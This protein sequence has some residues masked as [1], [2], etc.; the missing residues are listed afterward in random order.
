[1][2]THVESCEHGVKSR[3][4]RCESVWMRC[5]KLATDACSLGRRASSHTPTMFGSPR[6][7]T[8]P[9]RTVRIRADSPCA[10]VVGI[11]RRASR[12][13]QS[14]R[15]CW[16]PPS[17]QLLSGRT[18]LGPSVPT[19]TIGT[20]PAGTLRPDS[21]Y[22]DAPCWEPPSRQL[23]SG[24]TLPGAYAHA[25]AV[26]TGAVGVSAASFAAGIGDHRRAFASLV[27]QSA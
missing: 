21:Y 5:E 18:L 3:V 26:G 19:V 13:L 17:R 22:R 10:L 25:V 7:I 12:Q 2:K 16:D 1:M 11:G 9:E 14:R 6:V 4:N 27:V 24:R 23:L 8:R 20:H 15:P